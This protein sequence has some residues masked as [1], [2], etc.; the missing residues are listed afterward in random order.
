MVEQIYTATDL[1]AVAALLDE[2]EVAYIYV[3]DL[4]TSTYGAAG[5]EKFDARLE[6]A[7]ANDLGSVAALLDELGVAYI[8][9][10]DL[11]AGTYG[12]AGLEKFRER[13][14]VAY[15]N[16]RVTIYRWQPAGA[17]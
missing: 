14:E 11:E 13:L 2:L 3:G 4:E 17:G 12:A 16:D 6:V 9:V 10:G 7:F 1:N 5:L 15:S 8:Y